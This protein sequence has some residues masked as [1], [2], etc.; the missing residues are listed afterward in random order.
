MAVLA[1]PAAA[2]PFDRGFR[3]APAAAAGLEAVGLAAAE[4]VGALVVP[5]AVDLAV[6]D[7]AGLDDA[8]PA[9]RV[10]G[11]FEAAVELREQRSI[12][13]FETPL[14]GAKQM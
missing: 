7:D 5:A 4:V 6:V 10:A 3:A 13:T 14:F 2:V 9:A 12:I 8:A 1:A 11:G